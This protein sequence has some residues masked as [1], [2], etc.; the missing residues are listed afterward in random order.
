M[1]E[2]TFKDARNFRFS[3]GIVLVAERT[4]SLIR[5][6]DIDGKVPVKQGSLKSRT[7]LLSQLTRFSL[8]LNGTVPVLRK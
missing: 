5:F 6:I 7:D 3:N 4:S 8:R 2:G 1:L